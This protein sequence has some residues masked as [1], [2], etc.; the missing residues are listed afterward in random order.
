MVHVVNQHVTVLMEQATPYTSRW[1]SV[2]ILRR[3]LNLSQRKT[4]DF[5]YTMDRLQMILS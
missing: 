4:M 2:K 5:F 1:N 3:V